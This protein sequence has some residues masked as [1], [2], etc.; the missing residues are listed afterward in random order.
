VALL[1]KNHAGITE[2]YDTFQRELLLEGKKELAALVMPRKEISETLSGI[3]RGINPAD[4]FY[5]S[6]KSLPYFDRHSQTFMSKENIDAIFRQEH[7]GTKASPTASKVFEHSLDR[8]NQVAHGVAWVPTGWQPTLPVLIE[9][10]KRKLINTWAGVALTPVEGDVQPWLDLVAFVVPDEQERNLLI[11]WM[12]YQVQHIG[13]KCNWQ[14][15]LLGEKGVGKDQIFAPLARILGNACGDVT[16]EQL[17]QGW[18]DYTAKKKL[19]MLQEVYRPQNKGFANELKI[20]A[21]DTAVGTNTMN[22]KGG[23][24][25]EQANVTAMVLMSNHKSG[26]TLE[27]GERRYFVLNAFFPPK[28]REYYQA[29]GK[30]MGPNSAPTDASAKVFNYLLNVDLSDF[31]PTTS[32]YVTDAALDLIDRSDADYV[33]ELRE[34]E[35]QGAGPFDGDAF[36]LSQVTRYLKLLG[37]NHGRNGVKDA[38]ESLG[39]TEYRGARKIDGKKVSTTRFFTKAVLGKAGE[40]YDYYYSEVE[41]RLPEHLKHLP[42]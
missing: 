34:L 8:D 27:K 13:E 3:V 33:Q 35:S 10:G 42:R 32:P 30:W 17:Q 23:G 41:G 2:R 9:D 11:Q 15:V 5:V 18:G 4:Y 37:M 20:L 1:E 14:I 25:V 7:Q 19:L 16:A 39:Y 12:A 21:A 26:F 22:M 36:T 29:W 40:Q 28:P 31:D 38:I 6:G 24:V